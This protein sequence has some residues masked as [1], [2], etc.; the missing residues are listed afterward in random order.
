MSEPCVRYEIIDD[1]GVIWDFKDQL[2]VWEFWHKFKNNHFPPLPETFGDIKLVKV[3]D[4]T[5]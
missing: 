4:I 2:E 3:L 5:R 1:K